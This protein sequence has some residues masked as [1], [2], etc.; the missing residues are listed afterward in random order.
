MLSAVASS[1]AHPRLEQARRAT[2]NFPFYE[3]EIKCQPGPPMKSQ[4][5]AITTKR[6]LNRA[7]RCFLGTTS[8]LPTRTCTP[9]SL[10][11]ADDSTFRHHG[12]RFSEPDCVFEASVYTSY[13]ISHLEQ[14]VACT[15][16]RRAATAS[17][18]YFGPPPSRRQPSMDAY[19][20]PASDF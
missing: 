4:A 16:G 3:L 10:L 12:R 9:S 14:P 7:S 20:H 2:K 18:Y 1:R 8:C 5:G 13:P 19:R 15:A 11:R 6:T 17:L